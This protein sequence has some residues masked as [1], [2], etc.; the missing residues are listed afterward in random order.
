V[1]DGL[2]IT[3]AEA[4]AV[5]Y[6]A[7]LDPQ[8]EARARSHTAECAECAAKLDTLRASDRS[9]G[10][11]LSALDVP[12]PRN[13]AAGLI[14]TAKARSRISGG[15]LRRAAAGILAFVVLAGAAAAAIPSS[16][17]HRLILDA[18]ARKKTAAMNAESA[19]SAT[20]AAGSSGISI[21]P[22]AA[23]EIVFDNRNPGTVHLRISDS[24][25]LALTSTDV[26]A[27]YR[28]ASNRITVSQP[29]PADFNLEVPRGLSELRILAGDKLIFSRSS[30]T[31]MVTDTVTLHLSAPPRD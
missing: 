15:A 11:L 14:R 8:L 20:T 2:H 13:S 28:V 30:A 25:R 22:A 17:L 23:L 31:R 29:A 9:A 1:S 18:L 7:E 26:T 27:T 16:P 24:D 10:A 19:G 12:A 3:D 4:A 5:I 6:A 21:T